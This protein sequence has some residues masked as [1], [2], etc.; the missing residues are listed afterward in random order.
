MSNFLGL[1]MILAAAFGVCAVIWAQDKWP[2][3]ITIRKETN[4]LTPKV[5]PGAVFMEA[6][7]LQARKEKGL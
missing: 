1:A 2:V 7:R 5:D 3:R 6:Q 4:D